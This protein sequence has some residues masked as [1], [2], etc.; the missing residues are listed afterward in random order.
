[1]RIS[2]VTVCYNAAHTLGDAV[3]SVLGQTSDP[4]APFELEYIV[5][6]GGSTDGTLDL[7]ARHRKRIATLISEPDN[8]LYDAMNKGI[9]AA[10]GDVVAILNAD[11]VYAST[12]VLAR[13]AATFRDSGVEAVYGDLHYVTA[14]DLSKVTRSWN[15]GPYTP[16]AFRRGWMP[17]HPALFIHRAC[18]D[19][20]GLFTLAL[21]SA[22][23][24]ELMLRF[25]HRHGMT[26][27]YLPETLVLM[28]AGGVSNA[29]LKHRIRAHREDWKAWRMNG[30]HPSPMTML[31]KPLRK[32]P[33][34]L[35]R[36]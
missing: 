15:A 16:G 34:F 5:V 12:D 23:D 25:I 28:R 24:Y 14:D 26:L 2:V 7:L 21:R 11:D 19:R 18:Y 33:Q 27:A 32:L 22:A 30:Y 29:S 35:S 20:W 31:A 10:T 6:D 3:D 36:A 4:S 13:V 1:M 9:K 17:P 8:G